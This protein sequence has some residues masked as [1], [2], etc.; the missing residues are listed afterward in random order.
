RHRREVRTIRLNKNT[1]SR[2]SP[3]NFSE[4][5]CIRKRNDAGERNPETDTQR[6]IRKSIARR[7]A[8][9]YAMGRSM[10][11]QNNLCVFV[12]I[13]SMNDHRQIEFPGEFDLAAEHLTLHVARRIVVV[14][15]QARLS[16]R[17]D[18]AVL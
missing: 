15:I 1:I 3:C 10:F 18:F 4:P 6:K 9:N 13:T 16:D 17:D 14:V 2:Y 11:F 8:M 12:C 5:L 7:K